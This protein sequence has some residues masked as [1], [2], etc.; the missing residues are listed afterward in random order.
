MADLKK[1][2]VLVWDYGSMVEVARTLAKDFGTVYYYCPWKTDY[3]KS[4]ELQVGDGFENIKWVLNF[5]DVWKDI[6]LF[7]FPQIMDGD[8]QEHLIEN[9]KLVWGSREGEALEIYREDFLKYLEEIKLPTPKWKKVTG[10]NKLRD[11]LYSQK[12]KLWIKMDANERGNI[13]T[14]PYLGDPE[15]CEL[16]IIM[17]LEKDLG[18]YAQQAVFIV[19]ADIEST[20]EIGGDPFT[21]DGLYPKS[22]LFGIEA[23]DEGYVGGVRDWQQLPEAVKNIHSKLSPTL[24]KY[25]YRGDISSEIKVGVDGKFYFIDPTC[26]MPYPPTFLKLGMWKNIAECMYEGAKGNLVEPEWEA[27]FGCEIKLFSEYAKEN[28]YKLIVPDEIKQYVKQ[29]YIYRS[30]ITGSVI[31]VPQKVH[32]SDVGSVIAWDNNLDR[33]IELCKQRVVMIKGHGLKY[34]LNCL[35]EAIKEFKKL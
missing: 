33:A 6:D 27:L 26:R 1:L 3:S 29:P 35:D 31:I 11:A 13:E 4:S 8:I 28:D 32:N 9:E 16:S 7:V 24:K 19:M 20:A 18:S 30:K 21:I 5:W 15:A 23:K 34:D 2:S 25:G 14:F 12:E 10:I 22:W 17:P